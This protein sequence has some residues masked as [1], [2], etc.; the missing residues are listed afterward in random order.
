MK[1]KLSHY[2]VFSNTFYDSLLNIE[3]VMCLSTRTLQHYSFD[4]SLYDKLISNNFDEIELEYM[5][6]LLS[7]EILVPLN[8]NELE[9]IL[10]RSESSILDNTTLY[11]VIQ[12]SAQCQL[13]CEYCGQNHKNIKLNPIIEDKVIDRIE[14]KLQNSNYK[15]LS[16]AWFG[17]EPMVAFS[18]MKSITEKLLKL[19]KTYDCNY[20][21]KIVTNGLSVD[22]NKFDILVNELEVRTIEITLDGTAEYHD[23]RRFTK[24]GSPTFERIFQNLITIANSNENLAKKVTITVRC[25]V[26]KRNGS[27]VTNLIKLLRQNNLHDKIS[28]YCAPIHSWGNDAHKLSFSHQEFADLEIDWLYEMI[29]LDFEVNLMPAL[30][31]IVCM[32]VEKDSEVIDAYGNIFSCTEIPYVD[33][34]NDSEHKLGNILFE[35]IEKVKQR[36]YINFHNDIRNEKFD[37][38]KCKML[39][40]CGGA[41][42]KQWYEGNV[43]CPSNKFNMDKKL[44]LQQLVIRQ[45]YLQEINS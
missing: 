31:P 44:I 24:N 12:P 38:A 39:P 4:K 26:D 30:K 1:L 41:C 7:S 36:S 17:G 19:C 23:N 32:T 33:I 43:P 8:E 37:C 27:S 25:N 29:S 16:I 13:G 35:G 14:H 9:T 34:Y 40:V 28:F 42:P 3:K 18:V 45:N 2:I 15:E 20:S 10:R 11:Y 5:E 21:S 6:D 22:E